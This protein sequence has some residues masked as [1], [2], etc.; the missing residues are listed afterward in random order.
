M[1][2][3]QLDGNT[4]MIFVV[5]RVL[6]VHPVCTD[7]LR[8]SWGRPFEEYLKIFLCVIEIDTFPPDHED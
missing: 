3:N 7:I 1:G 4:V 6:N 8:L 5:F 2:Y